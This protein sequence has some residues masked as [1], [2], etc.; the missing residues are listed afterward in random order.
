[1]NRTDKNS[2]IETLNQRFSEN[3]H[4]IVTSFSGLGANQSN[5]LR[6]KIDGCGGRYNVIKN[7]LAKRAAAG[8]PAEELVDSFE[9][10]CGVLT[11]DSDPV[12]LAKALSEFVKDNPQVGVKIGLVDGKQVIDEAGVTQ[13]SKMP[14]LPELRAKMLALFN[15]PATQLVRLLGTPGTQLAR[16]V[17]ARREQQAGEGDAA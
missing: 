3:P 8:T 12:G 15:T 11:H 9:G 2:M 16:V 5:A 14:G 4:V 17:D 6:R 10:P 7:R 1:M 13:L